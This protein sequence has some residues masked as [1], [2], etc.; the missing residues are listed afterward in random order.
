MMAY[1]D[2]F[3]LHSCTSDGGWRVHQGSETMIADVAAV[4]GGTT[5]CWGRLLMG[6]S[7]CW[8]QYY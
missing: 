4:G 6:N 3:W 7:P 1:Y 5:G 2:W 8:R